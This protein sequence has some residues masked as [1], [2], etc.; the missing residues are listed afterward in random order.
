MSPSIIRYAGLA[1]LVPFFA[2]LASAKS[3]GS[4]CGTYP[5]QTYEELDLHRKS[6]RAGKFKAATGRPAARLA[7]DILVLEDADGVVA[8]RNPFN[9]VSQGVTFTPSANGYRF[10]TA[11]ATVST[12][13]IGDRI[14]GLGDDDTREFDL[15]FPFP[16][17]GV[18]HSKIFVNSDGNLTFGTGDVDTSARSLGRLNSGPPRIA[19]LFSD[20]DPSA[21]GDGVNVF[22]SASRF[23]VTWLRVR[24]YS[25]FGFGPPQSFQITL[26]PNGA[27]AFAWSQVTVSDSVVGITPGSLT[28]SSA[29]VS[30]STGSERT[31]AGTVA[32]SFG[33]STSVDLVTASQKVYESQDDAYDYLAFFNTGG[34][35]A[36]NGV[37]AFQ[38]S[39]RARRKGIGDV[40]LDAGREYG[41]PNRLQAVLNLGPLSQYPEDPNALMPSRAGTG[42]TGLTVVAHEAGHL[43]LAFAS[44]REGSSRPMLG[45]QGFHWAFTFNSEASLLEGNRIE[46]SGEGASPRF[47]T[48][49]TVEGFSPL[50]QY[51]MGLRAP[52]DVPPTFYVQNSGL[53]PNLTAPRVGTT[54]N[55]TRRNIG[56]EEIIAAEGRRTPD[57]TVEQR[58]YRIGFVLIVPTGSTPTAEELAKVDL[59]RR[60]LEAA[61]T[62]YSGGRASLDTSFRRNLRLSV[63]PA[64]GLL[65][66]R[67][68]TASLSI[69]RPRETPVTVTLRAESGHFTLPPSVIIPAGQTSVPVSLTAARPGVDLLRAE[70]P[71]EFMPVEARVQVLPADGSGLSVVP[72]AEPG[73][74]PVFRAQDR[75]ELPYP[76]L[77]LVAGSTVV[78]TNADGL[79]AFPAGTQQVTVQGTN[80]T[81]SLARTPALAANGVVNAA[82]FR[83]GIV[84]GGIATAFGANLRDAEITLNGFPVVVFFSNETQANFAVPTGLTQASAELQVTNPAGTAMLTVPVLAAQPGIFFDAASG[85]AAAI[86]RGGTVY[87]LY[88]TGFGNAAVSA[89]AGSRTIEVLFSGLA[90]GFIGLQQ[91]NIRGGNPGDQ[92]TLTAGGVDSN[93]V[94]LP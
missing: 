8:R 28:G 67:S 38:V 40:L 34:V 15:P 25:D 53:S 11:P 79:A 58:R 83:P 32:E 55:G 13:D 85:R 43:F 74:P 36:G 64:A 46:D 71:S 94:G 63:E 24:E 6:L 21:T 57:H 93:T 41:S 31:F 18:T 35:S 78:T 44:N 52:G 62:R 42:D 30:F 14:A 70:G 7:G 60:E 59:Y 27:I 65:A 22:R 89:R 3:N 54:F 39:V 86:P 77:P 26:T 69:D 9:L 19:A 66:G 33:N 84:P 56:V 4:W 45:R 87:E 20:L 47:R 49:A 17:F 23:T 51:L 16:F 82:S 88:G 61:W 81:G 92:V 1:L 90:P 12:T 73:A 76:G 72:A 2:G 50:D 80:I 75:N 5:G 37:I 68:A 48:I 91:V 10:S 29:L